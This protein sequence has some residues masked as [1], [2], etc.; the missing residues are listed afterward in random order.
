[1]KLEEMEEIIFGC[2]GVPVWLPKAFMED[3][4]RT[5]DTFYCP[6][7]HSRSFKESTAERLQKELDTA[8]NGCTTRQPQQRSIA[9]QKEKHRGK[10]T[11]KEEGR[12][13]RDAPLV[14][15]TRS[16]GYV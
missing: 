5:K 16:S 7:G 3:K 4:R 12:Y 6:N 8:K 10:E 15:Q 11:S 13:K 2:C 14:C 1:M 9:P